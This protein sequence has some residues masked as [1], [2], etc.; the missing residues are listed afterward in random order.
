MKNE[1]LH[2]TEQFRLDL[3]GNGQAMHL[4]AKNMNNA[5]ALEIRP[6]YRFNVIVTKDMT[7]LKPCQSVDY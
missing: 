1:K 4:F 5:P 7:F 6:E 2:T 3:T